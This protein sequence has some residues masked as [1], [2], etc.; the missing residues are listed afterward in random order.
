MVE[1]ASVLHSALQATAMATAAVGNPECLQAA[2]ALFPGLSSRGALVGLSGPNPVPPKFTSMPK[3][4]ASTLF[5]HTA[6]N[7]V[8]KVKW[9]TS[10]ALTQ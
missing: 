7:E 10:V 9:V 5:E 2:F 8:I 3:P 6:C 1:D 4:H